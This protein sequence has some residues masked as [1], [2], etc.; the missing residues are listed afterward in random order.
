[1]TYEEIKNSLKPHLGT[2]KWWREERRPGYMVFFKVADNFDSLIISPK[3]GDPYTLTDHFTIYRPD[4]ECPPKRKTVK[5][6]N[7]LDRDFVTVSESDVLQYLEEN[8]DEFKNHPAY[9][10]LLNKSKTTPYYEN[11]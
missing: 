8:L 1:M 6:N 11:Y 2:W 9:L 4:S 5:R 3:S 7:V 10:Y